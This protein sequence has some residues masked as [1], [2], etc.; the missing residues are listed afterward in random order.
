MKVKGK[1]IW[2]FPKTDW[3]AESFGEA[4]S[5]RVKVS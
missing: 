2:C 3:L 1:S 4:K 5:W